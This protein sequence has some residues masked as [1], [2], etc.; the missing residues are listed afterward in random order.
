V[1]LSVTAYSERALGSILPG[2]ADGLEATHT[3]NRE[4]SVEVIDGRW[5]DASRVVP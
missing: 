2:W 4:G 1:T 5:L 3:Y